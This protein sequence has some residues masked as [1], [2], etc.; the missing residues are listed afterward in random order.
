MYDLSGYAAMI[1]DEQRI[2][3]YARALEARVAPGA[4]V[5][6]LG[7][8]SGIMALLACRAGAS[9]VY[10]IECSDVIQV[11]REAAAANGY[12][13][14]ICFLQG[15]SREIELPERVDGI[16]WDLRGAMPIFRDALTSLIDARDRWLK[17]GGW[18]IAERDTLW[19]GLISSPRLYERHVAGW[20]HAQGFDFSAA[21]GRAVNQSH[22]V[23]VEVGELVVEP[24]QW[25]SLEYLQVTHPNVSG[26]L[27]WTIDRPGVVHGLAVWFDTQTAG[28]FGLSNSPTSAR[29]V[30]SQMLLPWPEPIDFT[31]GDGV[32]IS[33]RADLTGVDYTLSWSTEIVRGDSRQSPRSF[34]QSTFKGSWLSADSLH[35]RSHDYVPTTND[36]AL[37]DRRVLELLDG[38]HT[39]GAIADRIAQEFPQQ[40]PTMADAVARVAAVSE[41]Y[42]ARSRSAAAPGEAVPARRP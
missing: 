15:T 35:R 30:Y 9:R 12:A 27:G 37:V 28:G 41:R 26:T 6:D 2:D 25:A 16:V 38:V 42:R 33:L 31:P 34:R 13:D 8:G 18:L 23:D 3:A 5:A 32:R 22:G 14:R 24:R 11:A 1:V 29:H 21:R 17:P 40:V 19:A 4:V 36:W 7:A 20:E 10:A 39:L